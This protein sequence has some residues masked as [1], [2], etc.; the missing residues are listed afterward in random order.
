VNLYDYQLKV[1][2]EVE[3]KIEAGIRRILISLPTGGGKTVVAG[4]LI[5]RFQATGLKR[6][7]F[8]AHRDELLTQARR[9][10]ARFDI[11]AGIIKAERDED[12]RPQALVQICSIQTLH[13]RAIRRKIIELPPAEVVII[14][15][16]HHGRARTYESVVAAY[17]DAIIIGLTATPCRG[18]GRG[19]GNVFDVIVE[20]PQIAELI[21]Q[22]KLVPA[23]IFA[24]APP[25]LTGVQTAKTG[26]YVINQLE[27][28]MNTDALVGDT[29]EHYLRHGQGRR[30]VAFTVDVAHSVHLTREFV[31]SG[32]KAEHLD[33]STDHNE[34]QAILSRLAS[35]ET[36]VVCNCSVLVEGFDLPSLAC[37]ILV[38]PTKSLLLYRQM[39]GRGLRTD[40]CSGKTDCIIL[41]HAGAVHRH[42]LPTDKI[43]WTLHTDKRAAN[44]AHESRKSEHR[45][46]FCE[47]SACGHVRLRGFSCL[48]C[49]WEPKRRGQS[50]DYIDD[51]LIEIGDSLYDQRYQQQEFYCEL[52]GYAATARKKDGS[53]YSPGWA[54]HKYIEKFGTPPLGIWRNF[55]AIKPSDATLR[56]IKS[57]FIAY[58]KARAAA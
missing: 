19:L 47:C 44:K 49:G 7:V 52:K 54:Y 38:R 56:W 10:F 25:D 16:G 28:V 39:I 32:V 46:A 50:I 20:G 30:A 15:E 40:E 2:E 9:T 45:D 58:A 27:A 53:P 35:G 4:E 18:D 43:E 48:N 14:D 26:D 34:R 57:R 41:D 5:R 31:R 13:A 11:Q 29:V 36:Q 55:P 42:G 37:I 6:V 17:P 51:N 21:D 24:P 33:G 1:I 12:A 8:L 23:K 3:A 22:K